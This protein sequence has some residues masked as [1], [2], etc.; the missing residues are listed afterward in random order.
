M[1]GEKYDSSRYDTKNDDVVVPS[2]FIGPKKPKRKFKHPVY[3][4]LK[5]LATKFGLLPKKQVSKRKQVET[6]V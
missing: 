1:A 2:Q 4:A 5:R 3:R 6:V